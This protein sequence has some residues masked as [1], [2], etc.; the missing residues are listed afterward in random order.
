MEVKQRQRMVDK[1][2]PQLSIS[3][4]CKLLALNR[5]SLYY[6]PQSSHSDWDEPLKQEILQIMIEFPYYG[7]RK[8]SAHLRSKGLRIGRRRATRLLRQMGLKATQ[9]KKRKGGQRKN[10]PV[11]PY[12]LEN[13]VITGPNQ[14]W[15]TDITYIPTRFGWVYLMAI[16]DL[17]SRMIL[18]W[19]VNGS[20]EAAPCVQLLKDTV[21]QYGKPTTVNQDQGSQFTSHDWLD[22]LKQL[23]ILIS[24]AG[25]GRCYDNIRVERGWRSLKQEEVYLKEYT[26]LADAKEN[27][28]LY[29]QQYNHKR[30]HQALGYKIPASV[31]HDG[32]LW[33]PMAPGNQGDPEILF[34]V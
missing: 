29:I 12:L 19:R 31:Y 14:V 32:G 33:K 26:T 1:H 17:Y 9:P 21:A 2:H 18:G 5:S 30:L 25:K 10:H 24:M 28:G 3:R 22:T 15:G 34:R 7:S 27:I 6:P 8:V 11:H 16:M 4:Q 23:G 20:L 13:L